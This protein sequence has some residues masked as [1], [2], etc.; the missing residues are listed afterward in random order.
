MKKAFSILVLVFLVLLLLLIIL[1]DF[2]KQ[3]ETFIAPVNDETPR[4]FSGPLQIFTDVPNMNP[5]TTDVISTNSQSLYDDSSL[6]HMFSDMAKRTTRESKDISKLPDFK[7]KTQ[8]FSEVTSDDI[9]NA[10]DMAKTGSLKQPWS[11]MY[12]HSL[13][14]AKPFEPEVTKL[15][16]DTLNRTIILIDPTSN[17]KIK[18]KIKS[19]TLEGVASELSSNPELAFYSKWNVVIHR[20]NKAYGFAFQAIFLH[21]GIDLEDMELFFCS[22]ENHTQLFEDVIE[23]MKYLQDSS[24]SSAFSPWSS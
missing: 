9:K 6:S 1:G 3:K 11:H 14:I 18:F 7:S 13:N 21:L 22:H 8:Y 5:T 10:L 15:L 24:S 19:I 17:L 23:T 2:P 20:D 4:Q 16:Q 12:K